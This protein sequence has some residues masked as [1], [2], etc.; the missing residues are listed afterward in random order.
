MR[1]LMVRF[2]CTGICAEFD[3]SWYCRLGDMSARTGTNAMFAVLVL[4]RS[5]LFTYFLSSS[6]AEFGLLQPPRLNYLYCAGTGA[7]D[8]ILDISL[9]LPCSL[10]L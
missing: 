2:C 4:D 8:V 5:S 3:A 9:A 10:E 1:L 7:G 6:P